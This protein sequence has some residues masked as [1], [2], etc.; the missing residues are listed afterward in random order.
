MLVIGRFED[1]SAYQVRITG[2][3]ERPVVGSVRAASLVE[4]HTGE[5][6]LLSPTGPRRT[7]AGD[8]VQSVRAVLLRHTSVLDS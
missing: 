5:P 1:G 2:D 4:L 3:A 6:V 8:D 7:V